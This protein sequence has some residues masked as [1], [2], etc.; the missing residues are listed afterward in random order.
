M[1]TNDPTLTFTQEEM[2]RLVRLDDAAALVELRSR[3]T[4]ELQGAGHMLRERIELTWSQRMAVRVAGIDVER[5]R[6]RFSRLV[7]QVLAER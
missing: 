2:L 5:E 6:H 7:A 1:S 4:A 3:T